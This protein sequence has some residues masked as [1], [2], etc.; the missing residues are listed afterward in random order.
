MLSR[1][2]SSTADPPWSPDRSDLLRWFCLNAPSLA[3]T[4]R[5]AVTLLNERDF[6]ARCTLLG[7]CVR[8]LV[9]LL[10][11]AITGVRQQRSVDHTPWCDRMLA[12]WPN[13]TQAS[14][15]RAPSKPEDVEQEVPIPLQVVRELHDL[16]DAHERSRKGKMSPGEA[17]VVAVAGKTAG[18]HVEPIKPLAEKLE[19]TRKFFERIHH[20][21]H[22]IRS[23]PPDEEVAKHFGFLETALMGLTRPYFSVKDQLDA[24][25]R[26]T[27]T[28]T[29]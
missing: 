22:V 6:P 19:K 15:F 3:V 7:F 13:R 20:F 12:A 26:K 1:T 9:N 16:L 8:D 21:S 25:L 10:P 29:D 24:V 23:D 17:M 18:E 5:A 14:V 4:Y 2:T 27:N 11:Q 28:R